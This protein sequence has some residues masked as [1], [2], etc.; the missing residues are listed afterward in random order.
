[1]VDVT[2][3][4]ADMWGISKYTGPKKTNMVHP[5]IT[6]FKKENHLPNLH[7]LP[8]IHSFLIFGGVNH[9]KCWW[10]IYEGFIRTFW[11][12]EQSAWEGYES[13]CEGVLSQLVSG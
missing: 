1:M 8:S 3:N 11:K 6:C 2:P 7:F 13:E 12:Y 4:R 9:G 10:V 5:K